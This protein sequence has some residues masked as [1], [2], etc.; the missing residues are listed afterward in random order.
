M[1]HIRIKYFFIIAEKLFIVILGPSLFSYYSNNLLTR[2]KYALTDY[3][4]RKLLVV[5]PDIAEFQG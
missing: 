2:I 4:L 3:I 1:H 5:F